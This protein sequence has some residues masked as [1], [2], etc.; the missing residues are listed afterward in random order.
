[1]KQIIAPIANKVWVKY[2]HIIKGLIGFGVMSG[3]IP[4]AA[5]YSP[6]QVSTRKA[7]LRP[8]QADN[9]LHG[10]SQYAQVAAPFNRTSR[11]GVYA[12]KD[13]RVYNGRYGYFVWCREV[14]CGTI[15]AKADI[16]DLDGKLI[17]KSMDSKTGRVGQMVLMLP[18]SS[19]PSSAKANLAYI[20]LT[21]LKV[22]G[23]NAF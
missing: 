16:F 1:M 11:D 4:L 14:A 18:F 12:S 22:D 7:I 19:M 2:S 3:F 23:K 5:Y 13:P 6:E 21:E 15:T 20:Q 17:G 9:E 8:I 10:K